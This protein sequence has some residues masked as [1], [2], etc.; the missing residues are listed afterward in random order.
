MAQIFPRSAT[1]A[2]RL[3]LLGFV[4]LI[5]GLFLL[6]KAQRSSFITDAGII[7]QQPV[8][9]SH[10]H[11]SGDDGIDCRYCHGAVETSPFAGIPSTEVC[12]NCHRELWVGSPLLA[13]VW[14]SYRSG[15]PILWNRVYDLPD[16]VY[17]DHS[18]HIHKGVGCST[19]HGRV[20]QMSLVRPI[21]PIVMSW[22][23]DCHR[24]PERHLRPV[25]EVFNMQ[26][27]PPPNQEQAGRQLAR[28]Y[29]VLDRQTL[30]SCNICHR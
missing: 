29:G 19:C 23:L 4:L 5:F 13:P 1:T 2:F 8:P 16:F 12:L 9:F 25:E 14:N 20:D 15:R 6:G 3:I 10:K 30:T 7:R 11:H 18:I 24:H 17:F 28:Q 26:W 27:Q 21:A 22:C